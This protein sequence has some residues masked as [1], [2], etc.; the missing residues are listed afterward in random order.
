MRLFYYRFACQCAFVHTQRHGVDKRAIGRYFVAGAEHDDIA[1][2]NIF[3]RHL[4]HIAVTHD[5]HKDIV[6]HLIQHF[7]L[8]V[9]I[10]FEDKA[11]NRRQN[12]RDKYPDRLEESTGPLLQAKNF[13]RRNANR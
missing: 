6:V 3:P 11:D 1:H 2:D 7:K 8:L 13:I 10:Q 5:C 9:G 4:R 12:Y